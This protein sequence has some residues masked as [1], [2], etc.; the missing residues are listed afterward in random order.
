MATGT[1][2]ITVEQGVSHDRVTF[3]FTSTSGGAAGDT[4]TK[5]FN[6]AIDQV[7]LVPGAAAVQPTDDWDVTLTDALG[8]DMLCGR[9]ANID[10]ATT[11]VLGD[12]S[13]SLGRVVNSALTL[14]VTNLGDAKSARMVVYIKK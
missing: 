14:A 9:G 10:N 8:L 2:T 11:T 3:D 13:A 1:V 5:L 7:V 6:G 12:Q 4:T